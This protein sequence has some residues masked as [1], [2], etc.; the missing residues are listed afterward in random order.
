MG[1]FSQIENVHYQIPAE[2]KKYN[3]ESMERRNQ[4]YFH[5]SLTQNM[6]YF[7]HNLIA[8]TLKLLVLK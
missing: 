4:H 1:T 6:W 2:T 7:P 3:H 8:I 5:Y